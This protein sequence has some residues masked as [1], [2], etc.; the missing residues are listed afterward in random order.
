MWPARQ[1]T[2]KAA[3]NIRKQRLILA[4][5]ILCSC[6]VMIGAIGLSL[7][8]EVPAS[9]FLLH[10]QFASKVFIFTASSAAAIYYKHCSLKRRSG[11]KSLRRRH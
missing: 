10:M 7:I 6:R 5:I 9:S 1:L 3:Q 2:K 11:R 4:S 8:P